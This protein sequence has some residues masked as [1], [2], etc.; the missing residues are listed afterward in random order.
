MRKSLNI[1]QVGSMA[2]VVSL[3][4]SIEELFD[5]K[6]DKRK[7]AEY[8]DWVEKINALIL[9]VNKESKFKMYEKIK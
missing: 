8:K 3:V 7:K 5:Q 4:E 2:G 1:L 6:P 9:Q